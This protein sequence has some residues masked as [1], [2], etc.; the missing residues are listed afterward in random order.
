M[1]LQNFHH[2]WQ[3][4]GGWPYVMNDYYNEGLMGLIDDPITFQMMDLIDPYG[5]QEKIY[6]KN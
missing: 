1:F 4:F 5:R 2:Y 3:S 6:K